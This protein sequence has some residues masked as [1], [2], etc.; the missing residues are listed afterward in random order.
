MAASDY[1]QCP[2]CGKKALYD[3]SEGDGEAPEIEVVHTACLWQ[4]RAERER[5]LREQIAKDIEI[6]A[7][8]TKRGRL[9]TKQR[10]P[11][12]E[13]AFQVSAHITRGGSCLANP[14]GVPNRAEE[15]ARRLGGDR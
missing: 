2:I 6:E 10:A 15:T 12:E 11:R 7:A 1:W 14:K 5:A 9:A 3:S 4:D 13:M 8:A